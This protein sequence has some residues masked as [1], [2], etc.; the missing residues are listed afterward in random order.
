MNCNHSPEDA[1]FCQAC[2]ER[3]AMSGKVND[4]T[5]A[6]QQ[7]ALK[8]IM[9]HLRLAQHESKSYETDA[10]RLEIMNRAIEISLKIIKNSLEN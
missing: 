8:E 5:N 4:K 7:D 2:R 3:V 9:T 1:R 10:A 6:E